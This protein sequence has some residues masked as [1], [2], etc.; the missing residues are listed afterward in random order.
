MIR[1]PPR[2]TRPTLS[3]PDALPI[4][5]G[6]QHH[7]DATGERSVVALRVE[8][9]HRRPS[10]VRTAVALE[11]L[12][13]RRLARSVGPEHRRDPA[14]LRCERHP[15]DRHHVSV[16]DGQLLHLHRGHR[17]NPQTPRPPP[18]PHPPPPTHI[19]HHAR[20]PPQPP[21]PPPRPHT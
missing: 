16:A 6:L 17:P 20:T 14:G 2:S 7:A 1:I 15:V 3:P 18:P 9:D 21:H 5:A 12:D 11:H 4:A 13:R 10:G 19:P 8:A